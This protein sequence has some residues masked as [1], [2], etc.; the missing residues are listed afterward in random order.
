M[1]KLK[2]ANEE[3][4]MKKNKPKELPMAATQGTGLL[5]R[6]MEQQGEM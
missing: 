5:A 1:A 4:Q 6:P 2:Y 3:I